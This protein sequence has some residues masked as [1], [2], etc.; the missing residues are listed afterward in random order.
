MM[1]NFAV[2]QV[3]VKLPWNA[4]KMIDGQ[5]CDKYWL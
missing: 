5:V 3:E 2:L 1:K 4:L